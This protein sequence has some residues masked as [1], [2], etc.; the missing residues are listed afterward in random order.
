MA[1]EE[2]LGELLAALEPRRKLARTEARQAGGLKGIDN[3]RDQR[4]FRTHDGETGAL[5]LRQRNQPGDVRRG[6]RGIAAFVL[7]RRAGIARRDDHFRHPRRL[8]KL[9]R[10]RM[11]ASA[12][13]DDEHLHRISGGNAACR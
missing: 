10:Q 5:L 9:P 1:H 8:C 6:N 12:A 2:F 7:E 3:A 13:A 4:P 11:F